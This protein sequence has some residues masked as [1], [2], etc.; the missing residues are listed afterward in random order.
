MTTEPI[1]SAAT[2]SASASTISTPSPQ[3]LSAEPRRRRW[4]GSIRARILLAL[5]GLSAVALGAAGATLYGIERDRLE[6]RM[7]DSL[8]RTVAEVRAIAENDVDPATGAPFASAEDLLYFALQRYVPSDNEAAFSVGATGVL[9]YSELNRLRPD[10]DGELVGS[11][12]GAAERTDV[13]IERLRTATADYRYVVLPVQVGETP[14]AALVVVFDRTAELA[15]L[16]PTFRLYTLIAAIAL[17]GIAVAGWLIVEKILE[18]L[19]LLRRTAQEIGSGDLERRI[20]VVGNDDLADMSVT[21]NDM[22]ARLEGAFT[23]QQQLLDDVGHELRTPLTVVRGHL[24]LMDPD[25]VADATATRTLALDELDRMYHLVDDLMTIARVD[26][27]DFVSPRA[28]D[29]AGLTDDVLAK[30]RSLGERRW[31]LDAL[32]EGEARLDPQRITQAL[33][34]LA[35]NAVRYSA[36]GS[37]VGVGSA[38]NGSD[39]ELWVRDEGIGIAE[40]EQELVLERF[41]RGRGATTDST[42]LGLA[43]VSSIARAHGGEVRIVSAPGRGT[44]VTIVVPDAEGGTLE[45]PALSPTPDGRNPA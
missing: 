10:T 18:P 6:E 11:L 41:A 30:A 27:P 34:Q 8:A 20:P 35:S 14:P 12:A 4:W 39:L 45:L 40:D 43:I 3:E 19:R 44:T 24:E 26:R 16:T 15:T 36:D 17:L 32:A 37:T 21:I 29:V 2:V 1:P 38:W 25:D 42:G 28:C 22:L 5:V 7:D 33:L 31:R 9:Q 23:A 13:A